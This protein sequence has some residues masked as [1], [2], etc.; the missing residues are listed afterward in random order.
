MAGQFKTYKL[1]PQNIFQDLLNNKNYTPLSLNMNVETQGQPSWG[2][3]I[4]DIQNQSSLGEGLQANNTS[5]MGGNKTNLQWVHTDD[6]KLPQYS[7]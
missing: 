2:R 4:N 3:S 6:S 7:K 5:A 1:V